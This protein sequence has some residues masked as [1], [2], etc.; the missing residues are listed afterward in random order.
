MNNSTQKQFT[1]TDMS[2]DFKGVWIPREIWLHPALLPLDK[3]C[4]AEIHSL[5]DRRRGGCYASNNYL[6]GFFGFSERYVREMISKLKTHG[7]IEEI[8]FNGRVRVIRAVIPPEDF[9]IPDQF[10]A[11][12][13][14]SSGQEGT[15]VPGSQEPQFLPPIYIEGIEEGIVNTPLPPKGE[16]VGESSSS[17]SKKSKKKAKEP[18]IPKDAFLENVLL[19]KD[20]YAKL[21]ELHG[22]KALMWMIEVLSAYIGSSGR[23]YKSH[24]HLMTNGGWV[25]KRLQEEKAKNPHL[26]PTNGYK[27]FGKMAIESDTRAEPTQRE[28]YQPSVSDA[29]A[30]AMLAK[31]K[32]ARKS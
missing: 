10:H 24:Y 8:S 28:T 3:M 23:A 20:E 32:A 21:L 2:R 25:C 31:L 30:D 19:S 13:N 15:V 27:R 26:Q 9:G 6:A 1:S 14:C 5:Y 12:R 18:E 4:W 22:E 11:E 17:S 7:L 16:S 29:E